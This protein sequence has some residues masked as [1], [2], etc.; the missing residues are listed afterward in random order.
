VWASLSEVSTGQ[1]SALALAI[2]LALNLSADTAPPLLLLDDP[3]AHADDLN[4]LS[5]FDYLRALVIH[6]SRQVVFAT[7]DEKVAYLFK[8]QV[9]FS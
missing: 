8:K 1:R 7:A 2:F 9:F 6:G 4:I 3:I 5:F